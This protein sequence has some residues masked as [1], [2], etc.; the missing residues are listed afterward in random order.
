MDETHAIF[1]V[2]SSNPEV[3][4]ISNIRLAAQLARAMQPKMRRSTFTGRVAQIRFCRPHASIP[5][6]STSRETL[7]RRWI[8]AASLEGEGDLGVVG[9]LKREAIIKAVVSWM[10]AK[11]KRALRILISHNSAG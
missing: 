8:G 7:S 3:L 5:S 11:R 1:W 9:Q 6:L 2:D 10:I 4:G